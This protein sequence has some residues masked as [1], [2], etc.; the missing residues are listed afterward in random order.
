MPN[1]CKKWKRGTKRSLGGSHASQE[2]I[3]T[4]Y[5]LIVAFKRTL[6]ITFKLTVKSYLKNEPK[7]YLKCFDNSNMNTYV[8]RESRP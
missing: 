4:F 7:S 5:H 8:F 2:S 6:K 1:M 3:Y